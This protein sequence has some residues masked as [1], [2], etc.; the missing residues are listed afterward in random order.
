LDKKGLIVQL[1]DW[2]MPAGQVREGNK[3]ASIFIATG[4]LWARCSTRAGAAS[5][6]SRIDDVTDTT[7]YKKVLN[8]MTPQHLYYTD[9][10]IQAPTVTATWMPGYNARICT[11]TWYLLTCIYYMYM[12][13][14]IVMH[15]TG[16]GKCTRRHLKQQEIIELIQL[17]GKTQN[18]HLMLSD[19]P[20]VSQKWKW[21]I[22][23]QTMF[24]ACS[25][26]EL[27]ISKRAL[28]Y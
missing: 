9:H 11:L 16:C 13:I 27:M 14:F 18:K 28:I 2:L 6:G 22:Y 3:L 8:F 5:A 4:A 20:K 26:K 17:S 15:L 12:F 23:N 10:H 7:V 21:D 25:N 24:F 19:I 1:V